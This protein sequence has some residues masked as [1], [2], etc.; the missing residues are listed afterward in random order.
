MDRCAR[1]RVFANPEGGQ[2]IAAICTLRIRHGW[3]HQDEVQGLSWDADGC[4]EVQEALRSHVRD[5]EFREDVLHALPL[6]GPEM[7]T[8]DVLARV[9]ADWPESTLE[10]VVAALDV[11]GLTHRRVQWFGTKGHGANGPRL[12]VRGY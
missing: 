2:D 8:E 7:A 10:D 6:F 4:L 5:P 1:T 11:W 3:N 12:Y 9:S